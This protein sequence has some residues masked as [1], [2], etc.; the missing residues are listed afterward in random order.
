MAEGE[1]PLLPQMWHPSLSSVAIGA[2][3]LRPKPGLWQRH[4]IYDLPEIPVFDGQSHPANGWAYPYV[5]VMRFE[6]NEN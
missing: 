6:P 3:S 4:D 2:R 1:A 5:G